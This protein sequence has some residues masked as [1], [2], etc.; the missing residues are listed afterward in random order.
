[1]KGKNRISQL[2]LELY[3]RGLTTRKEHRQVEK[4]LGS[5][6]VLRSRYKALQE[7]ELEIQRLLSEKLHRLNIPETPPASQRRR[8]VWGLLA[9][10]AIVCAF[11][12]AILYLKGN[13]L[14]KENTISAGTGTEIE[15]T[16]IP[17]ENISRAAAGGEENNSEKSIEKTAKAGPETKKQAETEQRGAAK[18]TI[19]EEGADFQS[20]GIAV[21]AA[22]EADTGIR[23]RGGNSGQQSDDAM[24]SEQ[25]SNITIPP[26]FTFIFENMF[27]NKQLSAVVIPGRITSIGKNAFAGNPL[28]SVTIGAN[29]AVDDDAIPGNFAAAYSNYGRAAGIYMRPDINSEE[30]GKK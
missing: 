10:A 19:I 29:V 12:P 25:Q 14:N 9:A 30:W 18:N 21:A 6:S 7:S 1:M 26:G 17:V 13:F 5:D 15:T 3:H 11:I 24:P 20:G 4:A 8:A 22:P 2:T 28:V 16:D 23:T 27:A